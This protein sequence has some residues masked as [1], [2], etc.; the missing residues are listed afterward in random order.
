M[1]IYNQRIIVK[2]SEIMAYID[3]ELINSQHIKSELLNIDVK[4]ASA[5]VKYNGSGTELLV[6]LREIISSFAERSEN[7]IDD[8]LSDVLLEAKSIEEEQR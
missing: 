3:V 4:R 7:T 8:I 5:N 1:I 6:L 2:G